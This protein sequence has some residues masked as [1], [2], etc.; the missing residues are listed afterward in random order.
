MLTGLLA[1]VALLAGLAGPAGA[2]TVPLPDPVADLDYQLGGVRDVPDRVGTVVRDRTAAPAGGYD[3]CYVNAFQTQPGAKRSWR[4]RWGLVLKDDGVP[5][6]DGAWGE[7]LLDLRTPAKRQRLAQVVGDWVAGCAADGFDAVE[8]D[9]LDSYTRSHGLLDR[10]D[11]LA[12]ARLLVDRGHDAGLAVAQKNLAG[13]DGTGLG[14]DLV[15]AEE[16]GRY[17][18]CGAYTDDFGTAVLAVEYRR[19]D[20]RRTCREVGEQ[21]PVVLRDRG[22]TPG[23]VRRFC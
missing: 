19:D 18:E 3:V 12:Y 9:N 6:V 23:G 7:W 1:A 5:V 11:A 14:F 16:C 20:F 22:V 2:A 4:Q 17:D 15:V 21:V 8:L 13:Y 10:G